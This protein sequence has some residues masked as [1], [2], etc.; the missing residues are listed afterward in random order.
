MP[1]WIAY[2]IG[3]SAI[4]IV[5]IVMGDADLM[6]YTEQDFDCSG[7]RKTLR[8]IVPLGAAVSFI[9]S[10]AFVKNGTDAA[11]NALACRLGKGKGYE[12]CNYGFSFGWRISVIKT[13]RCR[14]HW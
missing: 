11:T 10:W 9:V 5:F 12:V 1:K 4:W 6:D 7:D 14:T 8:I 2:G 3:R 13:S